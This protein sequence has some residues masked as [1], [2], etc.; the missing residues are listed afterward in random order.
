M[1]HISYLGKKVAFRVIGEGDAAPVVLL[2]GFCEDSR[3]WDE[4]LTL[5]PNNRKYLLIDLPGFGQSEVLPDV[6]IDSMAEAVMAVVDHTG[7]DRFVLVG[8]SMG[9][10]ISLAIAEG[11]EDRLTALCLF[12]S[13]PFADSEEKKN[14]RLKSAEFIRNNGH[15]LYVRQMIP[16]LFAYDFSKGYQSEVNAMIH[17]AAAYDEA[18]ILAALEAMRSRKDRSE[19]LSRLKIPVQFIVGKLD[20]AVPFELSMRQVHLP[21]TADIQVLSTVGHMGMFEAAQ[22]TARAFRNFLQFV[23]QLAVSTNNPD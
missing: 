2:H 19:V 14:A 23:E 22:A 13:H 8:H 9:G 10:Y 7:F 6:T 5:L 18:G 4:W 16:G 15:I 12:H 1:E 3:I 20:E 17:H 11:N 21:Q